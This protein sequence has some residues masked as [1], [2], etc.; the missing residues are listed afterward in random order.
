ML[1][2]IRGQFEI[3]LSPREP[4]SKAC[5][6]IPAEL[7]TGEISKFLLYAKGRPLSIFQSS[8]PSQ[9]LLLQI[10]VLDNA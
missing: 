2:A 5:V 8:T 3:A 9:M 6:D 7:R 4:C 10:L 1:I